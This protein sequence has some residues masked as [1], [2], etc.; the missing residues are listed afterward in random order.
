[1]DRFIVMHFTDR[2]TQEKSKRLPKVTQLRSGQAVIE[3]RHLDQGLDVLNYDATHVRKLRTGPQ[4]IKKGTLLYSDHCDS[5]KMSG[6]L[7]P[8]LRWK[9]GHG[10]GLDAL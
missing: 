5:G 4:E 8:V 1:M 7:F 3:S 2:V 9:V 10:T 6:D